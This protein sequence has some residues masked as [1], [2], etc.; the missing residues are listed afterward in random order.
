M[1]LP[2]AIGGSGMVPTVR[3]ALI[4][5]LAAPVALVVAAAAPAAWTVVPAAGLTLLA[6][7]LF[8]AWLAGP[9]EDLRLIVP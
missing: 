6:L 3:A 5:A 7:V 4:A 8:D 1:N 2:F 9:F